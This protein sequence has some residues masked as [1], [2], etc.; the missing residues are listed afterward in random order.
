MAAADGCDPPIPAHRVINARG[1]LSG[2]DA[3]GGYRVQRARLEAEGIIFQADGRVNLDYY[4]WLP[5]LDPRSDRPTSRKQPRN[6]NKDNSSDHGDQ[7]A[8]QV[9]AERD[10]LAKDD[11]GEPPT[12]DRAQNPEHDITDDA[13]ATTAHNHSR[14]PPSNEPQHNPGKNGHNESF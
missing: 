11:C 2:C 7:N 13:V 5:A 6:A 4:L 3:F 14:K 10:V 1:E 8:R 12:D 9:Q